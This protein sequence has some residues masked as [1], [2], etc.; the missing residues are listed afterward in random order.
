MGQEFRCL[1]NKLLN[2]CFPQNFLSVFT[3]R[4]CLSD[5]DGILLMLEYLRFLAI[6]K[7]FW[8]EYYPSLWI[9]EFW[10]HHISFNTKSYREFVENV[11]NGDMY[12]S[13][14]DENEYLYQNSNENR[15]KYHEK[16]FNC[17]GFNQSKSIWPDILLEEKSDWFVYLNLFKTLFT[18]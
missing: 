10:R 6:T 11:F 3:Q 9:L 18:K 1:Y 16:Y 15:E 2:F 4:Y 5:S 12:F 7:A 17:F 8:I 13:N 14:F